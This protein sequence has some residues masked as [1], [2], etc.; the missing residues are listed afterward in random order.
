MYDGGVDIRLV[1]DLDALQQS[2]AVESAAMAHD[3]VGLP[4]DPIEEFVPL[5]DGEPKAGELTQVYLAT[6]G[7]TPVGN[8]VLHQPLLDNLNVVNTEVHVHPEHRRQGVATA[9]AAF[10]IEEARRR[11]RN[12][13]FTEAPWHRDGSHGP[14]FPML[15]KLGA[16]RVLDDY[17]RILDL[18]ARPVGADH[19][20]PDGYEV[21][22]WVDVAPDSV[23]DGCA[24]LMGRMTVDAPM[25]DMDYEQEKWD[26]TRYR[27]KEQAAMARNRLRVASAVVHTASGQV[28][29]ITDIG[30]NRDRT[31]VAYQW[32][33]IVDP[34]HRGKRLGMVLK[35]HNHRWLTQSVQGVRWINTWNAASNT[36]MVAV[37]DALGFQIAERWSEW[38]LDL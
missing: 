4:C 36:Y 18:E 9:L 20:V 5:L 2:H 6:E 17:R 1:E 30:V 32:D 15:E 33:T 29:G 19:P 28:A 26:A 3:Y 7:G 10:A 24:Y 21:V 12:R 25:G 16:K 11:G 38:Q 23:V 37:N 35:T 8:L 14:A 22:Q 31:E 27:E 34:D 13:L